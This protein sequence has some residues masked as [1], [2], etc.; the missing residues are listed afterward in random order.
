MLLDVLRDPTCVYGAG[1][2]RLPQA[3]C[4][5]QG[6]RRTECLRAEEL[7][8]GETLGSPTH[9]EVHGDRGLIVLK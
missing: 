9:R 2:K 4:H 1:W 8:N 3:T 7:G 5:E 6:I